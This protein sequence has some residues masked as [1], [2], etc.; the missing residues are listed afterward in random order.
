[1]HKRCCSIY[2]ELLYVETFD[3]VLERSNYQIIFYDKINSTSIYIIS[4]YCSAITPIVY[5]PF[6]CHFISSVSLYALLSYGKAPRSSGCD[7]QDV[8]HRSISACFLWNH[9]RTPQWE[10]HSLLCP[11]PNTGASKS[12]S[13]FAV[14]PASLSFHHQQGIFG[15]C[16]EPT[17]CGACTHWF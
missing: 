6:I 16:C 13:S 4:I 1:M 3:I 14:V 12:P 7:G 8:I 2:V 9:R 11:I 15:L 10:L 5:H 17:C